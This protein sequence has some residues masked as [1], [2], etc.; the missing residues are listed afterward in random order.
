MDE[1]EHM[2]KWDKADSEFGKLYNDYLHNS[3]L[4]KSLRESMDRFSFRDLF[5]EY[6]STCTE[7]DKDLM[8]R[9][10]AIFRLAY[11]EDRLDPVYNIPNYTTMKNKMGGVKIK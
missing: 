1:M 4:I 8:V 3:P 10:V 2:E 9:L 7:S 5:S 6:L 11:E